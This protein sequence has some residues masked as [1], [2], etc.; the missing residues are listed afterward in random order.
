MN[1]SYPSSIPV[2]RG[3]R[4]STFLQVRCNRSA[5]SGFRHVP[6]DDWTLPQGAR[7]KKREETGF[8]QQKQM[9]SLGFDGKF[10][11]LAKLGTT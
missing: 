7:N 10:V 5:T 6:A 1:H 2:R 4:L 11:G 8:H 9:I 3:R